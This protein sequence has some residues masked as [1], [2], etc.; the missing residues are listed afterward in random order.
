MR[1]ELLSNESSAL[2]EFAKHASSGFSLYRPG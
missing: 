1:K 2:R